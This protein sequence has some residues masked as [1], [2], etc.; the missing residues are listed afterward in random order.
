MTASE[1]VPTCACGKNLHIWQN[2]WNHADGCPMTPV[3]ASETEVAADAALDLTPGGRCTVCLYA[4]GLHSPDCRRT[5]PAHPD[6]RAHATKN[7][8]VPTDKGSSQ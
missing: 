6:E 8:R 3:T 1:Q 2:P 7:A 5:T 4:L